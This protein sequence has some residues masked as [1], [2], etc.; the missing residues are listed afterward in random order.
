[1]ILRL[2]TAG[3]LLALLFAGTAQA[4]FGRYT[5]HTLDSNT[6]AV[7]T[8]LGT[9]RVTAID[10]AAF[11]VHYE[12]DGIRQLP[13]FALAGDPPPVQTALS[14]T[15][16]SLS[17]SLPGLTAVIH[18]SPVKVEFVKEEQILF[19]EEHGYFA[20]DTVRGFRFA[21]GDGEKILGAGQ[22]VVGMDRRGKR[23]PLY[24][25][26]SYGYETDAEQMY[27]SVPAIVSSDRYMIVFDNS[28][29]GWLDIG[30]TETDVLSFE[31]VGG[32]TAYLAIA[33][34][35]FP[36]LLENYTDV[37][38][39]QPLPPRWALGNYASRFG[40][41]SEAETRDVVRRFREEKIPL[42][43]VILDLYWFG[44]DIQGH[45]GNLDWDRNAWPNPEDMIADFK[46]DGVQTIAITE[47]FIL[48]P[49]K[50]WEDAVKNKVLARNAAGEPRR[51]NFYFGNTGLVDVFDERARDWFWRPYEM[52]FD[53]GT[54]GTWGDLGE[55]EVHPADALHYLSDIDA[56]ATADEVHNVYGH[57]WAQMVYEKQIEHAPNVRPLIMM[58]SGFAGTQRYGIVPW[59]G[60]VNRSWGGLKPQVELSLSMGLLGLAWTHSDLG[61]FA[62]GERF[63]RELY[64][65]WL[66]YGVFQ[67][68]YRPHAQEHIAPEPV[69]H[70]RKTRRLAREFIELRY[71]LL[72]YIYTLAWEN[73]R[74]GMPLMR[75]LFFEDFDDLS[76][77][78]RADAYLFG[79]A[80]FVHPVT[81]PGLRTADVD[82]PPGVWFDFWS[83]D[84]VEG[85]A[86]HEV[87]VS[88]S[89]IPVFVRA[90]SFVPMVDA[91]QTT[92][93]YSSERL[94]LHY[95]ADETISSA[96]GYMF[97]D[98]GESRGSL[99]AGEYELLHF[100]AA[101]SQD[102]LTLSF[103]REGGDY[104]GRPERRELTVVIHN[105]SGDAGDIRFNGRLVP[106]LQSW[107][108]TAGPAAVHTKNT[109]TIRVD[110]DHGKSALIVEGGM[111]K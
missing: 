49:S 52:L 10:D 13:S 80:F 3:V 19:A 107:P 84:R 44:P 39:R 4:D 63:D 55:P 7:Q 22:R 31:A 109:L 95:Y 72:P 58:R 47:P 8:E 37:T 11:E 5:S 21:L 104:T 16:S 41:R 20:Y 69:F 100:E 59:T 66:L 54:R 28:A 17:L 1:M 34:D 46:A 15:A 108:A 2:R 91:V 79:D 25:R 68:V 70:D 51:F 6:L 50:R 82:L 87:P 40:Y 89:S 29:N 102:E 36:E 43:A 42:D 33:G 94:T 61:G 9:L 106:V 73:S 71:R 35:S 111:R 48:S 92:A 110:W 98:D 14:E 64:L 86:A 74:S 78:D 83:G 65:R 96:S 101:R 77:F 27:Y 97:E 45:M 99:D 93:D 75:P 103:S 23:L 18:K 30:G 57:R 88:L 105:W 81:D 60:D 26:A 32:R 62:G 85:G 56:W 53:Q 76:L 38:G 12:E 24:N 67:P 90:G